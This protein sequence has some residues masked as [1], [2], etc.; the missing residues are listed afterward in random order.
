MNHIRWHQKVKNQQTQMMHECFVRK[1]K[2]QRHGKKK[3]STKADSENQTSIDLT[4]VVVVEVL[5]VVVVVVVSNQVG[6]FLPT[7][8]HVATPIPKQIQT[9][10][11]PP[12]TPT[13]MLGAKPMTP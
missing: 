1:Q 4:V 13:P 5:V 6:C 8:I 2:A 12:P 10:Q 9:N 7:N 11:R 3:K